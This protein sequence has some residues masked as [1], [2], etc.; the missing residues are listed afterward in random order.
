MG[1]VMI[2]HSEPPAKLEKSKEI[3]LLSFF[4]QIS[5]SDVLHISHI[6][7]PEHNDIENTGN[8]EAPTF[9]EDTSSYGEQTEIGTLT[10]DDLPL[11]L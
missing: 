4:F 9:Q 10:G 8:V 6:S 2:L 3:E 5:S 11:I 7:L 1:K